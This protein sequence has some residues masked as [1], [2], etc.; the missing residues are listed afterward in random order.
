MRRDQRENRRGSGLRF[1]EFECP[2][3]DAN[4][5]Y[6]DGFEVGDEIACFYCGVPLVVHAGERGERY[7]LTRDG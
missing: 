5:P 2:E 6:D 3:C 4:N 1:T 7:R